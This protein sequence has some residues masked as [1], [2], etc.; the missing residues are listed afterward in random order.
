MDQAEDYESTMF[1]ELDL[2]TA[3]IDP[4]TNQVKTGETQNELK[5]IL[6]QQWLIY[7]VI[8]EV[9]RQVVDMIIQK[10]NGNAMF[11]TQMLH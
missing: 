1:K 6:S 4:V 2:L 11:A 5:R 10:S 8:K 3:I 9:E 7:N